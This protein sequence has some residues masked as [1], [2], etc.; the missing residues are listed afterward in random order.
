MARRR[1]LLATLTLLVVAP[2]QAHPGRG[3]VVDDQ[4]N[5]YVSD[6]VRS[7]VWRVDPDGR[8]SPAARDVHAH[9]LSIDAA[10]RV[11]ADDLHYDAAN[12]TY[13]RGMVRLSDS[14]PP[15]QIIEKR[16]DP[17]GL[18]A[19]AFCATPDGLA[20]ARESTHTIERRAGADVRGS[21]PL[22]AS[23]K[24]VNAITCTDDASLLAVRGREI[25]RIRPDDRVDTIANIP[26]QTCSTPVS[27][28]RDLW[29]VASNK[30]GDLFTTDPGCRLVL[31]LS[32]S[33]EVS[34]V[35]TATEPWFPT[36]VAC[37]GSTLYILEHGLEGEQN[38]GPRV[39]ILEPGKPTRVLATITDQTG[40]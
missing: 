32:P 9:W 25:L 23:E 24:T 31:R 36:G 5:V 35:H 11:L 22:S 38:L 40:R 26:E 10:G 29:G 3:I 20:I 13:P 34:T 4:Q 2:A 8:V 7:V 18:D 14:G 28:L 1:T 6:A 15:E 12:D 33:G 19:G 39:T 27:G 16:P 21:I 17:H 37:H 30:D